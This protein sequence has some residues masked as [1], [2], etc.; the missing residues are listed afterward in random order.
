MVVV[1]VV[2]RLASEFRATIAIANGSG[3]QLRGGVDGGRQVSETRRVRLYEQNRAVGAHGA[4]HVQVQFDLLAPRPTIN[5]KW[6]RLTVLVDFPEAATRTGA[7]RKAEIG[8][9]GTKIALC[10]WIV[11]GVND[12]HGLASPIRS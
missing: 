8:A 12:G 2:A 7:G 1:R 4:D 5:R 10:I 9:I 6:A 11:V 3:A